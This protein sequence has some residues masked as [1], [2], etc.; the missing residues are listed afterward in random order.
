[1]S[2]DNLALLHKKL[3]IETGYSGPIPPPSMLS[4]YNA[5]IPDAA[6]RILKMAENQAAHRMYLEKTVADGD[7]QRARL[8]LWVGLFVAIAFL[9]ASTFL[10]YI[11][12]A[13]AGTLLGTVDLVAL[14]SVFAVGTFSRKSE[15][16]YKASALSLPQNTS[17]RR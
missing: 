16:E 5:I 7:T 9:A 15:R 17:R 2:R 14:V 3:D 11:G 8:G 13:V 4:A 6:N 1:M 12:Q 10:I